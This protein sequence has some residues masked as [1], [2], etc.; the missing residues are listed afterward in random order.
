MYMPQQHSN[1]DPTWT[2]MMEFSS[3]LFHACILLVLASSATTTQDQSP[4]DVGDEGG[5][6]P[7]EGFHHF[8]VLLLSS[9]FVGHQMPLI[10]V[11]E[12]LVN[13]GHNVTLFTTEVKGSNVVPQL[14]ERAGITF[15]SAGPEHRTRE[16]SRLVTHSTSCFKPG[17]VSKQCWLGTQ[18]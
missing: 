4:N 11:G 9:Y 5:S 15:L 12:E 7:T 6:R 14:V 8:R 18:E 16:V 1:F 2:C 13:R 3:P 10:A 17:F